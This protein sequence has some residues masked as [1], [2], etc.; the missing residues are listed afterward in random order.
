MVGTGPAE[1][2]NEHQLV[3]VMKVSE[4]ISFDDYWNDLRFLLK[5]PSFQGSM[6]NGYGDNIYHRDP[7]THIWIQENSHHSLE[8]GGINQENLDRDTGS[9]DKVLVSTRF[10]Y[11]GGHGPAIPYEF[12]DFDGECLSIHTPAHKS[13]FSE[14]FVRRFSEW[15][16]ALG[17]QGIYNTP[18]DWRIGP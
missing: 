1:K 7:A 16:H 8:D 18:D 4:I 15:F 5:R 11:W 14:E 17:M 3:Y 6:K 2:K 9:T 10:A 13:R 12:Q